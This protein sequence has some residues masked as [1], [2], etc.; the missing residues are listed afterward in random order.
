LEMKKLDHETELKKM[1]LN[2]EEKKRTV[3]ENAIA[4]V[5]AEVGAALGGVV[6]NLLMPKETATPSAATPPNTN[7]SVFTSEYSESPEH[8][9][10]ASPQTLEDKQGQKPAKNHSNPGGETKTDKDEGEGEKKAGTKGET[11][12]EMER[13]FCP[14]CGNLIGFPKGVSAFRCPV[15]GTI[16]EIRKCKECGA[17]IIYMRGAA[18]VQCSSCGKVYRIKKVGKGKI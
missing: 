11:G 17:P 1:E 9:T 10:P 4:P 7:S 12:S 16:N 15:C 5:A 8:H 18:N 6:P 3:M 2:E 14:S 13:A